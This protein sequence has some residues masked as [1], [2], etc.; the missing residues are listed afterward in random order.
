MQSQRLKKIWLK[1]FLRR[2]L[3]EVLKKCREA[4][5][6]QVADLIRLVEMERKLFPVAKIER[7]VIWVD[8]L[9]D[10]A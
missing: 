10:A 1:E 4:N 6:P 7:E 9:D 3:P 2:A 8:H 5:P